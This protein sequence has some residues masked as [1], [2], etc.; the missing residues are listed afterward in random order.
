MNVAAIVTF[1]LLVL[2]PDQAKVATPGGK[3]EF[4]YNPPMWRDEF[5]SALSPGQA[6]RFGSNGATTWTTEAGILFDDLVIFPGEYNIAASPRE[7]GTWRLIFHHDGIQFTGA[8]SEGAA[9]LQGVEAPKKEESKKL[10][11]EID[12]EKQA[13]KGVFRFRATF[14]PKRMEGTFTTA[15]AKSKK[16]KIGKE[17]VACTW[18]E[19]A[20]LEE[21]EKKL[22]GDHVAVLR[23][24]A[25]ESTKALTLFLK[26]G[27]APTLQ[28]RRVGSPDSAFR[29]FEGQ[30]GE[31]ERPGKTFV[32]TLK[33]TDSG[34]EISFEVGAN[35]YYFTVT[36][37]LFTAS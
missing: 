14:G 23:M 5:Q 36:D 30:K 10:V 2:F 6:W 26:G 11:V 4:E 12:K 34:A 15:K 22:D 7:D 16:V 37:D 17:K 19:R 13:P 25:G 27:D 31:V 8:T 1:V 29:T 18:L 33:S 21:L 35:A 24:E 28:V 20:D 32:H 3:M 9:S